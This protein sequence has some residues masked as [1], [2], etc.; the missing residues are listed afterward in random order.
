MAMQALGLD[1]TG[2]FIKTLRVSRHHQP[3]HLQ[4]WAV[5]FAQ[6]LQPGLFF[7][8]PGGGQ[9]DHWPLALRPNRLP[10]RPLRGVHL[11][12]ELEVAGDHHIGGTR[13]AKA[14]GIVSRLGQHP[15]QAR[16]GGARP[17][18]EP[19]GFVERARRQA[20]IDHHQGQLSALGLGHPVGPNFGFHHQTQTG[21]EMLKKSGHGLG[22]VPRLPHQHIARLDHRG[23][24]GMAGGRAGG[25]DPAG[26]GQLLPQPPHQGLG[27]AGFTQGHRV[28][29]DV[30]GLS[31]VVVVPPTFSHLLPINGLLDGSARELALHPRLE[32]AHHEV[33]NGAA[34]DV[35]GVVAR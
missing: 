35:L 31:G 32:G 29:P 21:L 30:H 10:Q 12:V 28:Q 4:R 17:K 6:G 5:P 16:I 20:A 23:E 33:V 7:A 14:L 26:L 15:R 13:L 11:G 8:L 19:T 1:Q 22:R 9:H 18:R 2:H 27:R 25:E 24:F 34:H 3:L